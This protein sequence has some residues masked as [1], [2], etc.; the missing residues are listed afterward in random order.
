MIR[1]ILERHWPLGRIFLSAMLTPSSL[2]E[3][4]RRFCLATFLFGSFF[5]P[6][7]AFR[8]LL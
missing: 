7:E 1:R 8:M 2:S 5:H 4:K 6:E 3:I